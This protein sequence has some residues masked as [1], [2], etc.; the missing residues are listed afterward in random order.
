[1]IDQTKR[2]RMTFGTLFGLLAAV[3][4]VAG[5]IRDQPTVMLGA[6]LAGMVAGNVIPYSEIKNLLPWG[7]R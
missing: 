6:F 2:G 5:L 7:K 1:M 4:F 3:G